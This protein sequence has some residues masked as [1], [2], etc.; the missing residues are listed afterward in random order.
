MLTY[1][2]PGIY[3]PSKSIM[4]KHHHWT[5]K[6]QV[7]KMS[8][9]SEKWKERGKDGLP[10]SDTRSTGERRS[11]SATACTVSSGIVSCFTS[12]GSRRWDFIRAKEHIKA[13]L[14]TAQFLKTKF[15][16]NQQIA[17]KINK[18][19]INEEMERSLRP[20]SLCSTASRKNLSRGRLLSLK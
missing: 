20:S 15:K 14:T 18:I 6:H 7:L 12:A 17:D 3:L 9:K 10:S 2:D 13:K 4:R 5:A 19:R 1:S 16:K 8:N 11:T